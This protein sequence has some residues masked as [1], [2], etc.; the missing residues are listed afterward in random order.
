MSQDYQQL[1]NFSTCD[2]ADALQAL[3]YDGFLPGLQFHTSTNNASAI[4]G[5]AH[6][7]KA[8]GTG[9]GPTFVDSANAGS[10]IVMSTPAGSINAVWGGL[11]STRAKYLGVQGVIIDGCCRDVEESRAMGFPVYA[12]GTSCYGA[13]NYTRPSAVGEP[14]D[15][16]QGTHS[17][18]IRIRPD[19]IIMADNNGVIRICPEWIADILPLCERLFKIDKLCMNDLQTGH[20]IQETFAK[21]RS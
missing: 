20:S 6:T 3:G 7:V 9:T 4:I 17:P 13:R 11:M 5:P 19:D 12:R 10:I 16:C 8:G 21:H 1:L 14:I 15:I 18:A 2:V